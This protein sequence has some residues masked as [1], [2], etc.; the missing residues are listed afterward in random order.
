MRHVAQERTVVVRLP[1]PAND[2]LSHRV[3][4]RDV[5][6]FH[7]VVDSRAVRVVAVHVDDG[8]RGFY[9]IVVTDRI[10]HAFQNVVPAIRIEQDVVRHDDPAGR[11]HGLV[12]ARADFPFERDGPVQERSHLIHGRT[13]P[14]R[15]PAHDHVVADPGKHGI[16]TCRV[17]IFPSPAI[18]FSKDPIRVRIEIRVKIAIVEIRVVGRAITR[19]Y[20]E[21]RGGDR[22]EVT[23]EQDVHLFGIVC[24]VRPEVIEEV[25]QNRIRRDGDTNDALNRPVRDAEPESCLEGG[26]VGDRVFPRLRV[27]DQQRVVR[28]RVRDS[29]A[30][31]PGTPARRRLPP[32]TPHHAGTIPEQRPQVE[33][34]ACGY[35][36]VC[37]H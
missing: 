34:T 17:K 18:V 1:Q 14:R 5:R 6:A 15:D 13:R 24:R 26:E 3:V 21:R 4:R 22:I 8:C 9:R 30:G 25:P 2:V 10:D 12:L 27:H 23:D 35:G 19:P 29:R 36:G 33:I 37:W 28:V 16:H 31:Q 32:R 20:E 7:R 11:H